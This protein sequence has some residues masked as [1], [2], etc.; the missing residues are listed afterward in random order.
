MPYSSSA[1]I[2][3]TRAVVVHGKCCELYSTRLSNRTSGNFSTSLN[4]WISLY[5]SHS[6][7]TTI[8]YRAWQLPHPV[9]LIVSMIFQPFCPRLFRPFYFSIQFH[10]CSSDFFT[11][12]KIWYASLAHSRSSSPSNQETKRSSIHSIT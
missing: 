11:N 7:F 8:K 2:F 3:I 1:I 9:F 4:L 12:S 5:H 6:P 10:I